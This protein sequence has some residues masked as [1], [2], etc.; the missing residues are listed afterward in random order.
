MRGYPLG[1]IR[2]ATAVLMTVASHNDFEFRAGGGPPRRRPGASTQKEN[3]MSL[4]RW[5]RLGLFVAAFGVLPIGIGLRRGR[6][7]RI[8]HHGRDD[9]RGHR[10][11]RGGREFYE[12]MEGMQ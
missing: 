3:D 10:R 11:I 5:I 12:S 6:G 9:P 8:G 1:A 2:K 4:Q 7:A